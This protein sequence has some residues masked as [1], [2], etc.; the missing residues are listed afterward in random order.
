MWARV[1]CV[2]PTDAPPIFDALLEIREGRIASL[3]AW[4]DRK[5]PTDVLDRGAWGLAPGLVNA[6]GHLNLSCLRGTIPPPDSFPRWLRQL[7]QTVVRF[8]PEQRTASAADGLVEL[9]ASGVT[10]VVDVA[11]SDDALPAARRSGLRVHWMR[12]VIGWRP[13]RRWKAWRDA[14]AAWRQYPDTRLLTSH[15]SPHA[16]YS[17][18]PRLIAKAA[19]W[20][21]RRGKRWG[22]HLAE[23]PEEMQL[24]LSGTG[25]MREFLG[26]FLG[27]RWQPPRQRAL[28]YLAG[29][30]WP[31]GRP[32]L[33]FHA[34]L[35]D[36]EEYALAARLGVAVVHCPGCH[37]YFN[38]PSFPARELLSRGIPLFLGTDSLA[39]NTGLD[40][41]RE[42]RLFVASQAG[43]SRLAALR[44]ASRD[45][46]AWFGEPG[47]PAG[48]APG[49]PADLWWWRWP[50][51]PPRQQPLEALLERLLEETQ[52]HSEVWIDGAPPPLGRNNPSPADSG[53]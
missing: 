11:S 32:P 51:G 18:H 25:P 3:S 45:A 35:L 16:P 24:L 5:S 43:I 7:M 50:E 10:T 9:A 1:G 36:A 22:M 21:G 4:P 34:N 29:L 47:A 8:T 26:D 13:L 28:Q 38:R 2:V 42:L 46:A 14:R 53:G 6:H 20:A 49:A 48:L 37:Q 39:S 27:R 33:L 30:P 40:M 31:R 44:M 15:V 52:L 17:V 23:T 12:E 19:T 41:R